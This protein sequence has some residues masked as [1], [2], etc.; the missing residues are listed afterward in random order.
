M[1]EKSESEDF[2]EDEA[3]E[4]VGEPE[5]LDLDHLMRD[6]ETQRRRGVKAGEPA[7]RRR[8]RYIEDKHTAELLSDFD[9]YPIGDDG[10]PNGKGEARS[11]KKRK[12]RRH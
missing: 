9:D 6:L 2:E 4:S 3:P 11:R 8:E 12:L 5:D 1:G 7:W 10:E